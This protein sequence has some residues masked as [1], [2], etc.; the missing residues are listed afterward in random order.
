MTP[1]SVRPTAPA[2]AAAPATPEVAPASGFAALLEA[3]REPAAAGDRGAAETDKPA[4][5]TSG[6]PAHER[7]IK[8]AR[9]AAAAKPRREAQNAEPAE[10][11]DVAALLPSK[12]QASVE[13][14]TAPG[15]AT[16]DT[17]ADA[18]ADG[19]APPLPTALPAPPAALPPAAEGA[20]SGGAS[21]DAALAAAPRRARDAVPT[22]TLPASAPEAAPAHGAVE[23]SAAP[24]TAPS[25][26][27]PSK[28][29]A[30]ARSAAPHPAETPPN[31]A[32]LAAP[33]AP[34]P[35]SPPPAVADTPFSAHLAAALESPRFAPALATQ[36]RWWVEGGVQSAQL[37]LNPADMGPVAVRIAVDGTQARIDFTAALAPTRAA[38][39]A[40]LPTLAATLADG[41]LTLAGGGVFDGSS[42]RQSQGNAQ[43][44]A[45]AH[46]APLRQGAADGSARAP[47]DPARARGLVDLVA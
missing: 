30:P 31:V 3:V 41:G 9:K 16:E 12:P 27:T 19:A 8:A 39:E 24:A 43:H 45:R 11:I 44:G 10:P 20:A 46:G 47:V 2:A 23:R 1:I 33:P 6:D 14:A 21:N 28:A 37:T 25:P 18:A 34:Q 38:I 13:G 4:E 15:S 40:S 17:R 32:S 22:D 29:D 35:T 26:A 7:T 36:V 5:A 42:A